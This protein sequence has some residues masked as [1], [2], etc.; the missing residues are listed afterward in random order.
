MPPSQYQERKREGLAGG[1]PGPLP[2]A[3]GD[4]DSKGS[5]EANRV[6][7]MTPARQQGAAS[8]LC[9]PR[10]PGQGLF[11]SYRSWRIPPPWRRAGASLR[12][13]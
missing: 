8:F 9:L 4:A 12:G 11:P 6:T 2:L 1:L 3:S 5:T 13:V 7:L 10:G